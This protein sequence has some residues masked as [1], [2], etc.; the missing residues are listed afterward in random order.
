MS[1][2]LLRETGTLVSPTVPLPTSVENAVTD[3]LPVIVTNQTSAFGE[4]LTVE[5]NPQV[6]MHFYGQIISNQ[7]YDTSETN[8]TRTFEN[9]QLSLDIPGG[10][11]STGDFANIRSHRTVKYRAGTGTQFRGAC[12]FGANQTGL[13]QYMGLGNA[14]SAFYWGYA[15]TS[16][17]LSAVRRHGGQLAVYKLTVTSAAGS[18]G[19]V[20]VTLNG[21]AFVVGVTN[22][23]GD[24]N[25][26][27]FEIGDRSYELAYAQGWNV[28]VVDDTV[29]W[30]RQSDGPTTGAFSFVDTDTTGAAAAAGVEQVMAGIIATTTVVEQADFN[31]DTLDGNGP[32]GFTINPQLGN[33]YEIKFQWHGY[34]AIYYNVTN[35][36]TGEFIT[37]HTVRYANTA[38]RASTGYPAFNVQASIFSTAD[39]AAASMKFSSAMAAVDGKITFRAPRFSAQGTLNNISANTETPALSL[40]NNM[41]SAQSV[42]NFTEILLVFLSVSSDSNKPVTIRV[43]ENGTIGAGTTGDYPDWQAVDVSNST[44]ET[45]TNAVT[46]SGGNQLFE[47]ELSKDGSQFVDLSPLGILLEK[48]DYITIS[49]ETSNATNDIRVSLTWIEDH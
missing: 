28:Q 20:T 19:N 45:D 37:A 15:A 18:A 26:T 17:T 23:G 32:S 33:V 47:L 8:G 30:L 27:A 3:P 7:L 21:Q 41:L 29:F 25:F 49:A 2:Q 35:P 31:G 40:R 46:N 44:A 4:L 36:T 6:Q 11:G 42:V 38:V 24:A 9:E 14:N 22:A 1:T 13:G 48:F 39:T 10:V 43:R 5:P 34:G 16:S 12:V